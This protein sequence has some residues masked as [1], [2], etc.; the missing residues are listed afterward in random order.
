[1]SEHVLVPM[2]MNDQDDALA[3]FDKSIA[4]DPTYPLPHCGKD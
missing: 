4:A 1:M 2:E 3:H